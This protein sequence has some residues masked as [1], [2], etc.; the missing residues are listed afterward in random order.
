VDY[1]RLYE[2]PPE[3]ECSWRCRAC[4]DG[5]YEGWKAYRRKMAMSVPGKGGTGYQPV[6]GE[7]V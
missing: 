5:L 2:I 1:T 6:S 3:G 4:A 7:E